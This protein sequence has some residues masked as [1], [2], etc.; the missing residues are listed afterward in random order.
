M[1]QANMRSLGISRVDA[2]CGDCGRSASVDVS[3][4]PDDLAV[5]EVRRRLRC[6]RCG[7]RPIETRPDW[8]GYWRGRRHAGV[9]TAEL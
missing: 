3:A 7:A 9:F 4:L 8:T 6:S 2:Y 1:D 5:P